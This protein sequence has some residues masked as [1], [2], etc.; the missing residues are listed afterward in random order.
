MAEFLVRGYN[1]AVA[2]VDVGDDVLV[3]R[4]GASDLR[5]VQ[6][7]TRRLTAKNVAYSQV[8]RSQLEVT[9]AVALWYAL[10]ARSQDQWLPCLLIRQRELQERHSKRDLSPTGAVATSAVINVA[11]SFGKEQ[12][13]PRVWGNDLRHWFGTWRD[14]P[15]VL[16]GQVGT[17]QAASRR[18]MATAETPAADRA[19]MAHT[20]GGAR[21]ADTEF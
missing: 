6:V 5:R 21:R 8:A 3:V 4:A 17:N 9:G 7:K 14:W 16:H 2:E 12:K 1:V 20:K 10:L 19:K 18:P 11:V 15:V 13:T